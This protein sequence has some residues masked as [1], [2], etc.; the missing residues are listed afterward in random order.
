[1]K[2]IY[3]V[4]LLLSV[5]TNSNAKEN[6]NV[7]IVSNIGVTSNYIWRGMTQTS[8]KG[9]T[10]GG[11]DIDYMGVYTGIWVTEVDFGANDTARSE[12][13]YYA[14]YANNIG[15][16]SYDF[17]YTAYKYAGNKEL[18]FEEIYLGVDFEMT[19][20]LTFGLYGANGKSSAENY[21]NSSVSYD[22]KPF[23]LLASYGGYNN[24]GKNYNLQIIKT[25]EFNDM[26]INLHLGYANFAH[27]NNNT[28][29]EKNLYVGASIE[30]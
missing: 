30:F 15:L 11:L 27:D 7:S 21:Y 29:N 18:D 24:I 13:D 26:E 16:L 20:S 5:F 10:Q 12:I 8:N 28:L 6:K 25:K 17:G 3:L 4:I 2:K 22:F 1:M 19:K 14:G 23:T 9:A